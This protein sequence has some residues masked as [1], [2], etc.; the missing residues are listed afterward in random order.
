MNKYKIYAAAGILIIVGLFSLGYVKTGYLQ[1]LSTNDATE[2]QKLCSEIKES[3]K[4]CADSKKIV[5]LTGNPIELAFTLENKSEIETDISV[6]D[7]KTK[8]IF[9]VTDDKSLEMLTKTA[10]RINDNQISVEELIREN[11]V[12]RRSVNLEPHQ[13][14]DEK[15]VISDIY[16]LTKVGTYYVEVTRRTM[17]PT[18]DGYI[19]LPLSDKIEIEIR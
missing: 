4:F 8:Y 16:D 3:L 9:K 1:T 13:T 6:G 11:T 5:A 7:Y 14:L 15:V 10:Q 2:S 18:E 19:E 17:H 12:R